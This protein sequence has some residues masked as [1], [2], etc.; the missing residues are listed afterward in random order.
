MK[1][2][3]LSSFFVLLVLPLTAYGYGY[4]GAMGQGSVM[5][6]FDAVTHGFGGVLSVDVGGMN[7]FGNPAELTSS[8]PL[9]SASIGPLILKQVVD[10]GMGKHTLTYAGMGASSFQ[11]G[12]SAGAA[13]IAL[14]IAKIR[15][16][17]YTGEY[18]FIDSNPDP[19]IAG[20]E[21]LT[22]RGGVWEAATGAAATLPGNVNIGASAGYRTGDI[23]YDYYWHHFS[24]SIPDSSVSWSREEGEFSWRAGVSL[25]A[26]EAVSIGSVYASKTE[27]CPSSIAAGIRVGNIGGYLPGFGLEA[28][29]YDMPDGTAWSATAFG[30]IHPDHN[31]YFRGGLGLSS[32]GGA[33]SKVALGIS[34]GATVDFGKT[35]L[36]AAFNYGSETRDDDVLGFPEAQTINDVVTAF[37]VG[38]SIEL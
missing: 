11:A 32:T 13:E 36:S 17:T 4:P 15:D 8:N 21:N 29:I 19:V 12:F 24:E 14:G 30:G 16:Y 37:T 22:V 31:L 7:L 25:A 38:A 27:N 10:D 18:F 1:C 2:L 9:V 34:M 5:P 3:A 28:R 35:D 23:T 6:G 33:D 20:F 26:G